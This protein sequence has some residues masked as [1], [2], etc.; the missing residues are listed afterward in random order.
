MTG[1][2]SPCPRSTQLDPSSQTNGTIGNALAATEP[3]RSAY[4]DRRD[5][6][7][8]AVAYTRVSSP[9][10][11]KKYGLDAQ[12]TDIQ[13]LA[14]AN[15]LTIA[16]G[17]WYIDEG[18]SGDILKR[19]GFEAALARCEQ[20][21]IQAFVV[22]KIDR[23]GRG[24][25]EAD[26]IAYDNLRRILRLGVQVV[27]QE[28][29]NPLVHK[30]MAVLAGEQ[31]RSDVRRRTA[32]K[33]EAVKR[34]GAYAGARPPF[35]FVVE[36][37]NGLPKL[38]TDP[39]TA[40]HVKRI[41]RDYAAGMPLRRLV[42]ALD[43]EGVP[44]NL[45]RLGLAKSGRWEIS[46]LRRMIASEVYVGRWFY[47]KKQWISDP[48]GK[49]KQRSVLRPKSDWLQV[50][51][52]PIVTKQ[53]WK[54]ANQR[55]KDNVELRGRDP[56]SGAYLLK[57]RV[58]CGHCNRLMHVRKRDGW[59]QYRCKSKSDAYSDRKCAV[60]DVHGEQLEA[61][62]VKWLLTVLRRPDELEAW[63]D[64][65]V[66]GATQAEQAVSA[67]LNEAQAK[68]AD[69][70]TRLERLIDLA[71]AGRISTDK[72]DQRAGRIAAEREPLESTIADCLE[73]RQ[74]NRAWQRDPKRE[75][76][77]WLSL[78]N[79][80]A[81]YLADIEHWADSVSVTGEELEPGE[82]AYL[83]DELISE[84][85]AHAAD[86]CR[87][88]LLRLDVMVVVRGQGNR[89]KATVSCHLDPEGK[90]IGADQ[91]W[92]VGNPSPPTYQ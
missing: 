4:N 64:R 73:Q 20:G 57:G 90:L 75:R 18:V 59:H 54:K 23:L 16:E 2:G 69:L 51:V 84:T 58:R 62:V 41:Y 91:T 80:A 88:A 60:S 47:R 83:R 55:L 29:Q 81:G 24:E 34:G 78:F 21:D 3:G 53:L 79:R 12:R 27:S 9:E 15:G 39:A 19:E 49:K 31:K 10:Q 85:V 65:Q 5:A 28:G 77:E 40:P 11:V 36:M 17:D 25:T 76:K 52:S 33:L 1:S 37:Q 92:F 26:D 68:L 14:A 8:N 35:G 38:V 63:L 46:T 56:S 43:A 71:E 61:A 42:K 22:S 48:S 7:V 82:N 50:D 6:D 74:R 72:Y 87:E 45:V 70:D 66:A 67:R 89:R 13:I 86:M 44:T 32:G 30:L